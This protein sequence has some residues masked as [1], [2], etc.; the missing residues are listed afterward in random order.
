MVQSVQPDFEMIEKLKSGNTSDMKPRKLE[1]VK[2]GYIVH[3]NGGI[4]CIDPREIK[5]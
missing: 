2:Q 1:D 5:S 4:E 3:E